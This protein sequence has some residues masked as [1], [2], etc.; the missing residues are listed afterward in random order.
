VKIQE[1][2]T[3]LSARQ[4]L[5]K[6]PVGLTLIAIGV[7]RACPESRAIREARMQEDRTLRKCPGPP[8]AFGVVRGQDAGEEERAKAKG[9]REKA[10]GLEL[11]RF[12][13][14]VLYGD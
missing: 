2:R 6:C 3:C 8:K 14:L 12:A 5:R 4:A 7:V 13:G 10:K 1:D 11:G 9:K